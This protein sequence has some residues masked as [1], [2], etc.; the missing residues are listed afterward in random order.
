MLTGMM[1]GKSL[2]QP[3]SRW[4][5]TLWTLWPWAELRFQHKLLRRVS[6]TLLSV[7]NEN[8]Q[9][10]RELICLGKSR[11]IVDILDHPYTRERASHESC[12]ECEVCARV[13]DGTASRAGYSRRFTEPKP[14]RPSNH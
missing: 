10:K 7:L 9:L 13:A 14:V 11:A 1:N 3:P 4:Q 5:K 6:K 8:M 12:Q 2:S